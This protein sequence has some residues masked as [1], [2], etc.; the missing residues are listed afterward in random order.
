MK[1]L[2][3]NGN[4]KLHDDESE[5]G[6]LYIEINDEHTAEKARHD[7]HINDLYAAVTA[8][9]VNY[10]EWKKPDQKLIER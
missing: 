5:K 6:Y 2:L 3:E 8:F 7:I 4:I 1:T 10:D 9:K